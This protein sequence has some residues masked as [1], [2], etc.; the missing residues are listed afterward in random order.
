MKYLKVI[1]ILYG[2]NIDSIINLLNKSV[3]ANE[4]VPEGDSNAVHTG[5]SFQIH[6][7]KTM[8]IL[9]S[10]YHDTIIRQ[11]RISE[12]YALPL[13]IGLLASKEYIDGR[14]FYGGYKELLITPRYSNDGEEEGYLINEHIKVPHNSN[15]N[16]IK[17]ITITE[18]GVEVIIS[19]LKIRDSENNVIKTIP[20]QRKFHK[21]IFYGNSSFKVNRSWD[22]YILDDDDEE[23]DGDVGDGDDDE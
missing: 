5:F 21:E 23:Y 17:E 22:E 18:G 20:L 2:D 14:G 11:L 7:G 6:T 15:Q 9:Y 16:G 1:E 3:F 4:F 12:T 13:L 10:I 19:E 8:E